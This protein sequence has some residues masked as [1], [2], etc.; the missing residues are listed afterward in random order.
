MKKL[1]ITIILPLALISQLVITKWW[2][3]VV[4]D[5][6]DE[7]LYGFPFVSRCRGFHTSLS[8]QY[9]ILEVLLNFLVRLVFW[10]IVVL[11]FKKYLTRLRI[12]P[13][14]V[15]IFYGITISFVSFFA[16]VSHEVDDVYLLKRDFNIHV[17]D[18]GL[19]FL[20]QYP[21]ERETFEKELNDFDWFENQN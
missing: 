4:L 12:A 3:G 8:H 5:G 14:L 13:T 18:S 10:S 9:F 6:T 16:F 17:F 7:F 21:P 20:W 19:M 1:F 2:Y 11:A 15:K